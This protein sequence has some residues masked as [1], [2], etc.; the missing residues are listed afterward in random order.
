MLRTWH[1]SIVLRVSE[2][3]PKSNPSENFRVKYRNFDELSKKDETFSI[4][5]IGR[6]GESGLIRRIGLK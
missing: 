3:N 1:Q 5:R 2:Q 4:P 6:R